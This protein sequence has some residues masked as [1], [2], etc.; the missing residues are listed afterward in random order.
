MSAFWIS[1]SYLLIIV[2]AYRLA[3]TMHESQRYGEAYFYSGII[4]WCLLGICQAT[5]IIS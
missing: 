1:I 3:R 2:F 4:G 5:G